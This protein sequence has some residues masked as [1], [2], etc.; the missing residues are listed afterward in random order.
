VS[1]ATTR[2]SLIIMSARSRVQVNIDEIDEHV[3]AEAGLRTG[4]DAVAE[5]T[6]GGVLIRALREGESSKIVG[7]TDARQMF[8]ELGLTPLSREDAEREFGDLRRGTLS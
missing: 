8:D 3:L 5:A 4:Q 6:E 7:P 1:I 2:S